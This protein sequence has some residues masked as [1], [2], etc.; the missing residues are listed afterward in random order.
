MYNS[1]VLLSV[2]K[3][4]EDKT[5]DRPIPLPDLYSMYE[6]EPKISPHKQALDFLVVGDFLDTV[7]GHPCLIEGI[8]CEGIKLRR[9][10]HLTIQQDWKDFCL[11]VMTAVIL[12][13]TLVLVV[14]AFC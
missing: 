7:D 4:I 6:G 10:L 1:K 9:D 8:G 14:K 13:L 2:L 5:D 12:V 3:D 11:Q